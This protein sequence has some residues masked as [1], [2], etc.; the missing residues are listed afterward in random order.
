MEW[1]GEMGPLSQFSPA[2]QRYQSTYLTLDNKLG[3]ANFNIAIGKGANNFS[4]QWLLRF[5]FDAP[6]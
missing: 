2:S 3:K 4:E 6:F 5:V 1:Y